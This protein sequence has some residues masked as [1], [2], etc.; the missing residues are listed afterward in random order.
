MVLLKLDFIKTYDKVNCEFLFLAL[1]MVGM[2]CKFINM[3]PVLFNNVETYI[4]LNEIITKPF[5]I[6][7]E[8][9]QGYLLAP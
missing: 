1:E 8:I 7:E 2:D 9:K 5:R 6:E 4:C 3:V